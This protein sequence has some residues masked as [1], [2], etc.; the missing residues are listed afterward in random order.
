MAEIKIQFKRG[1]SAELA[2]YV[3]SSG[4]PVF[5]TDLG[6]LKIGNNSESFEDIASPPSEQSVF[7][8]DNHTQSTIYK[9]QTVYASGVRG[10][11]KIISIDKYIADGSIDEIRFLG[12]SK[13][14]INHGGQGEVIDFGHLSNVNTSSVNINPSGSSWSEGDILYADPNTAGGLINFKPQEAISVAMVL[15]TGNSGELF[16]RPTNFGHLDDKHDVKITNVASG[17]GLIYNSTTGLWENVVV[18]KSD[19]SS[20]H[21]NASG[22]YNIV[23][24]DSNT[25]SSITKDPNTIYFVP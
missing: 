20:V 13:T 25:Y 9:G 3:P 19:P 8:V 21:P 11:G 18:P 12:L 6:L 1:T 15:A 14:D 22:V 2:S 23:I 10:G 7:L 16:V 5:A 4:E 17:D 24:V